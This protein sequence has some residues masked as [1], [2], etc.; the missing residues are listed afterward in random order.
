MSSFL[1]ITYILSVIDYQTSEMYGRM[2]LMSYN[3]YLLNCIALK[4]VMLYI[5]AGTQ[6][7]KISYNSTHRGRW[8]SYLHNSIDFNGKK[9]GNQVLYEHVHDIFQHGNNS[10]TL[11]PSVKPHH[12]ASSVPCLFNVIFHG[13]QNQ[14]SCTDW[15]AEQVDSIW[16]NFTHSWC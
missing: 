10:P 6:V 1:G 4:F 14:Q 2:Q 13:N 16:Y 7:C 9:F 11:W 15:D 5:Q 12:T 8:R 3:S